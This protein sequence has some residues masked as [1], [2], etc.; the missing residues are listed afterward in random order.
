M[1]PGSWGRETGG[2]LQGIET[3]GKSFEGRPWLRKG[4]YANDDDDDD[5]IDRD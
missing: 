4:Y 3:A 5:D 1:M 2:M